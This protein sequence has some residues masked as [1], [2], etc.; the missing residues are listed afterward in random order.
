MGSGDSCTR[1]PA[2]RAAGRWAWSFGHPPELS[3]SFWIFSF[4]RSSHWRRICTAYSMGQW[5]RRILS[6]ASSLS[7]GSRVPV[8]HE[9]GGD[10]GARCRGALPYP[11]GHTP[12]P[13][14]TPP[15]RHAAFLDVRDDQGFP[16]LSA[17][18]CRA[19]ETGYE[20]GFQGFCLRWGWER[21][22]LVLG[23]ISSWHGG[24]VSKSAHL[25]GCPFSFYKWVCTPC[26][27]M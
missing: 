27:E 25:S 11:H 24:G 7:P 18:R 9:W 8:L 17:G 12:C 14:G 3:S 15:V 4:T 1:P 21:T 10:G 19:E 6:M 2:F 23:A 13:C 16:S 26:G 22:L 5:S 20:F